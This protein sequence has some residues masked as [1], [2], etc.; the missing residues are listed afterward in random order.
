MKVYFRNFQTPRLEHF[1]GAQLRWGIATNFL[2]ADN[3]AENVVDKKMW[4]GR[5]DSYTAVQ[6][7]L[8]SPVAATFSIYSRPFRSRIRKV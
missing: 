7:F 6:H 1:Y 2:F 8:G 4:P 3:V 5:V